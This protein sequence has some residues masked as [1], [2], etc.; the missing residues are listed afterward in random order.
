MGP[1]VRVTSTP[2][3]EV[4]GSCKYPSTQVLSEIYLFS[5]LLVISIVICVEIFDETSC[6][7]S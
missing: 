4:E 6:A 7:G 2:F 1:A 5:P 3:Y